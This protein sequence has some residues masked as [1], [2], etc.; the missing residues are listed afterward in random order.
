VG[1]PSQKTP[2]PQGDVQ[3]F[4]FK[5][6]PK[7]LV[8]QKQNELKNIS[9]NQKYSCRRKR[10]DLSSFQV[11]CHFF[12]KRRSDVYPAILRFLT[13][14]TISVSV[15]SATEPPTSSLPTIQTTEIES[16]TQSSVVRF[17]MDGSS[18]ND[19]SPAVRGLLR[20]NRSV[21]LRLQAFA[22]G[23]SASDVL[24]LTYVITGQ[25]APLFYCHKLA[26]C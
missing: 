6:A 9:S 21:E 25:V 13:T 16:A 10:D 1:E 3:W 23:Q 22:A 5:N 26:V 17:T 15:L 11:P 12:I 14:F 18:V 2:R 4:I 24:S 7:F 8:H 19:S 20:I